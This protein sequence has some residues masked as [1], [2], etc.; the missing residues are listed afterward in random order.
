MLHLDHFRSP[1]QKFTNEIKQ[2]IIYSFTFTVNPI[3]VCN[4]FLN[5]P[6]HANTQTNSISHYFN[7]QLLIF[8]KQ[9]EISAFQYKDFTELNRLFVFPSFLLILKELFLFQI[10]TAICQKLYFNLIH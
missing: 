7:Q 4:C 6:H 1:P 8:T 9:I 3:Y 10:I 5:Y 2:K